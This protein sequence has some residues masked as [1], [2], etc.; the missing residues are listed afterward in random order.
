MYGRAHEARVF[1]CNYTPAELPP[2]RLA[3]S[4][5]WLT[6]GEAKP[7]PIP[8]DDPAMRQYWSVPLAIDAGRLRPGKYHGELTLVPGQPYPTGPRVPVEVE[9]VAP[10]EPNPS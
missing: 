1:V 6:A 4:Q 5:P 10:L 8:A 9:V 3:G 7:E 2:P